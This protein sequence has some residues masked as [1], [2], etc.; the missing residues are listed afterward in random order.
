MR[1]GISVRTVYVNS[2]SDVSQWQVRS[3]CIGMAIKK[4]LTV[5]VTVTV[6]GNTQHL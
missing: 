6:S 4:V 3:N 2:T 5:N 1:G